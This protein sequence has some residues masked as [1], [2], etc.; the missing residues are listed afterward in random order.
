MH[1]Y[2]R[3]CMVDR[4]NNNTSECFNNWILPYQDRPCLTMLKEIRCRIMKQFT[5][6]RNEAAIW[7]GQLTPKVLKELDKKESLHKK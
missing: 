7:K 2:D 4:A 1:I 3:N 6:R 5:K